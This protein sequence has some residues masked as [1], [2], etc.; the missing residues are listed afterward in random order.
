M[1]VEKILLD[2]SEYTRFKSLEHKYHEMK[3]NYDRLKHEVELKKHVHVQKGEGD[4]ADLQTDILTR[5]NGVLNDQTQ[6]II[7]IETVPDNQASESTVAEGHNSTKED[8][9]MDVEEELTV[10]DKWYFIGIPP[11]CS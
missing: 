6:E 8:E 11:C 4:S 7:P 3:S 2:Y 9:K 5:S 1:A 10:Q